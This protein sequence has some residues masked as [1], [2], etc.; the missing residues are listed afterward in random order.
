[1]P[2]WCLNEVK[3]SEKVLNAI[4]DN[5]NKKV[6]FQKLIP[7]PKSLMVTAGGLQED[8]IIYALLK[9]NRTQREETLE[10]LKNKQYDFYEAIA[11]YVGKDKETQE[12]LQKLYKYNK[13]YKPY[14]E[15]QALGIKKLR[16]LGNT[17]IAN[18]INYG[19]PNWYDWSNHN[20]GTKWNACDSYGSPKEGFLAFDT[21]WNPPEG[22]I[23]K[24]F[25]KFPKEDINWYYEEP[26]MCFA[27]NY[28]PDYCGG[29]IDTP[30]PVPDYYNEE[31][32]EMEDN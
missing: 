31:N 10:N 30:C 8:A 15:E 23:N 25:E 19:F 3:A 5:K 28:T 18:I 27:G 16:E 21:A 7:M 12:R 14:E 20:W 4:Y 17:Y 9:M 26:G 6:T 11:Q 32:E 1:M 22:I 24:L 13:E 29:V 2:N